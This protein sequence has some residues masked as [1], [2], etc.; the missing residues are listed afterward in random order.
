MQLNRNV[1]LIGSDIEL[2]PREWLGGI[3]ADLTAY[4]AALQSIGDKMEPTMCEHGAY[5]PDNL[6]TEIATL[7]HQGTEDFLANYTALRTH[8]E[9]VMGIELYGYDYVEIPE[10][11]LSKVSYPWLYRA[12]RSFGCSPD[13]Q[14]GIERR[15][16]I[17]VKRRPLREAGV[18]IHFQLPLP[19]MQGVY[20]TQDHFGNPILKDKTTNILEIVDEWCQASSHLHGWDHA[21]EA[22]WY[23]AHGTYR[24][25]PYGVEYRSLGGSLLN[26]NTKLAH[27]FDL[28]FTFLNDIWRLTA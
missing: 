11:L 9:S 24:I 22:P 16:P 23:R 6:L 12:S 5:H 25:K 1:P 14:A 15:V 19:I 21:T 4:E 7:P 20:E 10:G 28:A 18:H 13:L 26:N 2:A 27:V 8:V 17:E 3:P